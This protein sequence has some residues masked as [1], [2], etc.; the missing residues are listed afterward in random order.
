MRLCMCVR[1]YGYTGE[2]FSLYEIKYFGARVRFRICVATKG[3]G[4]LARIK[5]D[6]EEER[7]RMQ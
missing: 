1:V 5:R 3:A 7:E 4:L 6:E 2:I